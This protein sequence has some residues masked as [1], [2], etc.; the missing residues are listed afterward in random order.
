MQ[1]WDA[2]CADPKNRTQITL[3]VRLLAD[4]NLSPK[5]K[6]V[7][8]YLSIKAFSADDYC[9]MEEFFHEYFTIEETTDAI[10]ELYEFG[11]ATFETDID[12]AFIVRLKPCAICMPWSA[13]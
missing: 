11:Y 12:G 9:A 10:L 13:K 3:S 6:V 4:A 5:A 2:Y 7:A 8:G 1:N